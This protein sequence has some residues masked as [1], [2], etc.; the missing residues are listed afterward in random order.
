VG[1]ANRIRQE[2]VKAPT[3]AGSGG[4]GR[5]SWLLPAA[6]GGV[7]VAVVAVVILLVSGGGSSS[8][9][10]V[11]KVMTAAGCTFKSVAP[12]P[13]KKG[14]TTYHEEV[15]T[16]SSKVKWA[17]DPPSG[18]AHYGAWAVWNFY[19][20]AVNPRMVVHNEEHGGV[21]M[22]FGSKVSGTQIDKLNGFY[23]DSPEGMVGTLYPKLGDKIA[24]TAWTGDPNRYYHKNYYGIGKLAICPRFDQK[25]FAAFRDAFRGKGP[26]GVPLS[27]DVPGS[28]PQA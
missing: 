13:P 15:P 28:G 5:P 14:A 19:R 3:S 12:L 25:A 16:L 6:A 26:E 20:E 11:A 24:L 7:V 23:N 22:W 4:R 1:K 9:T 21:V 27:S 17:T 2:R 18:G 10:D 8:T